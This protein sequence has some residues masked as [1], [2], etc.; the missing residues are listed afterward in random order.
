MPSTVPFI[1]EAS[2]LAELTV[3]AYC[4]ATRLLDDV[5]WSEYRKNRVSEGYGDKGLGTI[6]TFW[7]VRVFD[8]AEL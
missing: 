6:G 7:V 8:A 2:Q 5:R 3:L 4:K 1:C